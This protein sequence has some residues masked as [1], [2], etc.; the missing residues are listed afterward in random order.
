MEL[1]RLSGCYLIQSLLGFSGDVCVCVSVC[2]CGS[3]LGVASSGSLCSDENGSSLSLP[4]LPCRVE[5][6]R[7]IVYF[8]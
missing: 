1:D 6:A 5:T 2:I 7:F 8:G 3:G 4:L